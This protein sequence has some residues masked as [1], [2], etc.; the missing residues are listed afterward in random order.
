MRS[1]VAEA[2]VGLSPGERL[3]TMLAVVPEWLRLLVWPAHLRADYSL[4]EFVASTTFGAAQVLGVTMVLVAAAGAI[5]AR[6]RAP[7]VT[8]GLAWMTL[9]LLPVSNLLIPTGILL[10]ERTL[11]LPSVGFLLAVGGVA[12]YAGAHEWRGRRRVSLRVAV[13]LVALLGVARSAERHL[14][15]KN[16]PYF[17]FRTAQDSPR[18]WRAQYVY[19]Q[20]LFRIGLRPDAELAFSRAIAASPEP[21]RVQHFFGQQLRAAGDDSA[22]AEQLRESLR[23]RPGDAAARAELV[24]ALIG[25]G[26]YSEA[27]EMARS[28]APS[29]PEVDTAGSPGSSREVFAGLA[30]LADSAREAGAA[31]GTVRVKLQLGE[32]R[33]M[34]P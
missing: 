23:Q 24:A 31:P 27:A 16:E 19:G 26:D 29:A 13:G 32:D 25:L 30:A 4:A 21:W 17:W 20:I 14:V 11:F 1:F 7:V 34:L 9:A 3:L 5:V 28:E 2:L 10:A 6:R 18:S 8:F 33:L 22:A 15:W 12:A